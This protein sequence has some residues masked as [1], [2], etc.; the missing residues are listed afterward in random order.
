MIFGVNPFAYLITLAIHRHF[1]FLEKIGDKKWNQFFGI[2]VRPVKIAAVGD[3]NGSFVCS[4]I[5]PTQMI[6]AGLGSGI[7]TVRFKRR[8]LNK[9]AINRFAKNLISGDLYHCTY[10]V[11]LYSFQ[12]II[13]TNN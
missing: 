10:A 12:K 13:R 2:L 5:G 3:N 4:E 7:R 11:F 1:L 8:R 9:L 6:T